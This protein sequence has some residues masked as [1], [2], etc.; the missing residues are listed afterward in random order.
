M[1]Y[2]SD[3]TTTVTRNLK[4]FEKKTHN[5]YESIAIMSKRANQ[6]GTEMR[7]S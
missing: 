5:I 3:V 4:E 6:I 2:K 1:N 7:K